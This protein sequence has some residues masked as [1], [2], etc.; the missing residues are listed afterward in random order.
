MKDTLENYGEKTEG[1]GILPSDTLI[2]IC[3]QNKT[4]DF[5]DIQEKSDEDFLEKT[6]II[7]DRSINITKIVSNDC[8]M[9][10]KQTY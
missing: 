8:W 4:L 6:N 7:M 3:E 9:V 2:K 1:K 10:L 5:F